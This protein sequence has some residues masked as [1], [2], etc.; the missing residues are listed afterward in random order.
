MLITRRV[1]SPP[2]QAFVSSL[3][4]ARMDDGLGLVGWH[5]Y[6]LLG[7]WGWACAV[8]WRGGGA[9]RMNESN[10]SNQSADVNRNCPPRAH[11]DIISKH[12]AKRCYCLPSQSSLSR[13]L[14][15]SFHSDGACELRS[16]QRPNAKAAA[17][18]AAA[19]TRQTRATRRCHYLSPFAGNAF[20]HILLR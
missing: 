16:D 20:P 1:G 5:I 13:N 8:T 12:H 18:A 17:A 4:L 3:T 19:A 9:H 2:A 10:E 11:C 14:P 15:A 6:S 7:D